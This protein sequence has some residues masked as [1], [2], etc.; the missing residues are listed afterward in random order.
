MAKSARARW[1]QQGRANFTALRLAELPADLPQS[2]GVWASTARGAFS[3]RPDDQTLRQIEFVRAGP[4]LCGL[5]RLDGDDADIDLFRKMLRRLEALGGSRTRGW[6]R[7]T[8]VSVEDVPVGTGAAPQLNLPLPPHQPVELRLL[9]RNLEPLNIARTAYAGNIVEGLAFLPGGTLCGALLGRLGDDFVGGMLVGHAYVLP[10]DLAEGTGWM[11]AQVVPIPLSMQAAKSGQGGAAD[12]SPWWSRPSGGDPR[13]AW[14]AQ[15]DKLAPISP[16]PEG[17]VY[18]RIKGDEWLVRGASDPHWRR[19]RPAMAVRLRNAVPFSRLDPE[20]KDLEGL[21]SEQVLRE[22]QTFVAHVRFDNEAKAAE[23]LR[24]LAPFFGTDNARAAW[25][26]IGRGGR[27]MRVLDAAI[28]PQPPVAIAAPADTLTLTLTSDLVARTPVLAFAVVLD[29]ALLVALLN[30]GSLSAEGLKVADLVCETTT[31]LGF[32]RATGLPRRSVLAI[33]RGSVAQDQGRRRCRPA[34]P[35]RAPGRA[36][37]RG[38]GRPRAR[39]AHRGRAGPVR[40]G[41]GRSSAGLLEATAWRLAAPLRTS[42]VKSDGRDSRK[43]PRVPRRQSRRDSRPGRDRSHGPDASVAPWQWLRKRGGMLDR[44]L[45]RE[46]LTLEI[47]EHS[48]KL[49]GRTD[50]GPDQDSTGRG[51]EGPG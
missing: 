25:L 38:P 43:S 16:K 39:R 18:K 32:N 23:F 27:P 11:T 5:I 35:R 24:R 33:R 14:P 28:A 47:D 12:G 26:R 1:D 21:F 36:P 34:E 51:A 3:R 50:L 20:Y 41:P 40:R 42:R 48:T 30:D 29:P 46:K 7:V 9:L 31:V 6:G 37:L 2:F 19:F 44:G 8:L 17:L 45:T 15:Q 13:P 22:G 49:A 4:V 10:D